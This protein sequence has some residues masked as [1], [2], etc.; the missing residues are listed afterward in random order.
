M[1]YVIFAG[2]KKKYGITERL[3]LAKIV[4]QAENSVVDK[5]YGRKIKTKK[6]KR[7]KFCPFCCFLMHPRL[8]LDFAKVSS[9]KQGYGGQVGLSILRLRSGQVKNVDCGAFWLKSAI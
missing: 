4:N 2:R 9:G 3:N 6:T 1:A 7:A 5:L 8:R